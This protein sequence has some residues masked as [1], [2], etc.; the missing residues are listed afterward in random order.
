MTDGTV[1]IQEIETV[2]AEADCLFT[3]RQIDAA[4]DNMAAAISKRL[5]GHNP[6]ILSVLI[7]GIMPTSELLKRLDF[8][9]QLDYVHASR[10]LEKTSGGTLHWLRAPGELGN[11]SVLVI[12]DILDEGHT[13]KAIAEACRE[14]GAA[15]VLTA[16]LVDKQV[17]RDEGLSH[18]DFTGVS[19]PNRYVFGCGM[20]YKGYLRNLHGIYAVKGM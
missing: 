16:V 5:A 20:D 19:I 10:Y 9:L 12:D 2:R 14:A 17:D 15:E 4:L 3:D 11:R 13:L 1:S 6:I 7:G 18:A 8:P